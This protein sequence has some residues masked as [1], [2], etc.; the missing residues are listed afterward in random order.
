MEVALRPHGLSAAQ[1]AALSVLARDPGVSGADLARGCNISPQA[2]NGLL[3]TLHREG[4][5]ERHPHPTHG[6]ILQLNLTK[7]GQ[8][9]LDAA[10]GDVDRLETIVERGLDA[11]Q[12][13]LI[14]EWLVAAAQR[15]V[16][17]AH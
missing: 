1:Y 2:M 3:A 13:A 16:E 6:R 8:R 14:K 10:R 7:E 12:V 4:L 11:E 9:R 17:A 15:M 5:V